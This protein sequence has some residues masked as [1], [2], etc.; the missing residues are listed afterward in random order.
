MAKYKMLVTET[1]IKSKTIEIDIPDEIYSR[2]SKSAI[3]RGINECV[4][5]Y[6]KEHPVVSFDDANEEKEVSYH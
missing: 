3:R 2:K 6:A 1:T 5:K 4:E